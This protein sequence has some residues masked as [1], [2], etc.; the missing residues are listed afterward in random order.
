MNKRVLGRTGFEVSE[1]SFGTV[2][3]GIPYGFGV[4]NQT[5][6]PSEQQA[7]K[8]LDDALDAGINFFDTARAYGRSEEEK[9]GRVKKRSVL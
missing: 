9:E 5:Q 1:I 7:I 8:L 6:M 4:K 3:L 2:E